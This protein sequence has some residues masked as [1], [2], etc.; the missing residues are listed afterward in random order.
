METVIRNL[1]TQD[2]KSARDIF[3]DAFD[4]YKISIK[5]FG[6]SWRNRSVPDSYGIFST[7]GDL[8]GIAVVLFY[9]EN[10]TNRYLDWL[11]VHSAFRGE[12]LGLYLLRH[13]IN[14]CKEA[15]TGIHLLPV[16]NDRIKAWYKSHGFRDTSGGYMNLHFYATR[17]KSENIEPL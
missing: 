9:K 7:D 2:Y 4:I 6:Y 12:N 5:K 14:I 1:T 15:G 16:P 13:V 17:L 11:A 8:L 10:G 3:H